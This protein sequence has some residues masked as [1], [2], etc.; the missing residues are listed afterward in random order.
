MTISI[1]KKQLDT[2]DFDWGYTLNH[3]AIASQLSIF[4]EKLKICLMKVLHN[5]LN[6]HQIVNNKEYPNITI[7]NNLKNFIT[8]AVYTNVDN[9]LRDIL[10]Q[11][12]GEGLDAINTIKEYFVKH[13]NRSAVEIYSNMFALLSSKHSITYSYNKFISLTNKLYELNL[14]KDQH[15]RT[16]LLVKG[17]LNKA[18]ATLCNT[19]QNN[20]DVTSAEVHTTLCNALNNN[21]INDNKTKCKL[22]HRYH[23]G[24]CYFEN[25]DNN[26][27]KDTHKRVNSTPNNN[28]G[29]SKR[30]KITHNK[31]N[32]PTSNNTSNKNYMNTESECDILEL[33]NFFNITY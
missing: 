15:T 22:C 24:K 27:E 20:N 8:T 29:Y 7:D 6:V 16:L 25:K 19:L 11:N 33:S 21:I 10:V 12:N 23:K 14:S 26:S 2:H 32:K 30:M 28:D 9:I 13:K 17:T 4:T 1:T 5:P 31:E 18:T 3:T